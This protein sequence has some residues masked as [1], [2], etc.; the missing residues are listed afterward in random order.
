MKQSIQKELGTL[1][2]RVY[3]DY[4]IINLEVPLIV[5][6]FLH[7]V[8]QIFCNTVVVSQSVSQML[9][10]HDREENQVSLEGTCTRVSL[11]EKTFSQH[12]ALVKLF[13][14]QFG[15]SCT[16]LAPYSFPCRISDH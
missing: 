6:T 10:S 15:Y 2:G 4:V 9:V 8:Q 16:R 14:W 3:V 11:A 7:H 13:V 5:V 1:I 12:A